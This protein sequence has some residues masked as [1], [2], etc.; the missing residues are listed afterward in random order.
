MSLGTEMVDEV[1]ILKKRNA[2]LG[3]SRLLAR[4]QRDK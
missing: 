4:R 2:C 1:L 3:I